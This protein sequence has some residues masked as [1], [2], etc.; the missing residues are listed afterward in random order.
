[1]NRMNVALIGC[2]RIGYL[3][4]D[5]PLRYKPCTHFGGAVSAG[6]AVTA[7]CD[8]DSARLNDFSLR[9][10]IPPSRRYS[11]YRKLIDENVPDA[12]IISTWTASHAQIGIAA[13]NS[14]AKVIV[15]EK[16]ICAGLKEAGRFIDACKK[17]GTEL[18]INH[19]RRY[20]P[21]YGRVKKM[22]GSGTIGDV[23]TV[24]ASVL[25]SSWKAG[26]GAEGGG[27]PLLH[28]GT[29][30]IDIIRFF[31]GDITSVEG[32]FQ[33]TGRKNG[34]EDRATAWLT[35]ESGVDVFLEAGGSRQYFV[36]E[37]VISGTGGKIVIGNG[38]EE[39]H[40]PRKSRFYTGF[41]D[42]N[43]SRFPA[44][45]GKNYFTALYCQVK[46]LLAGRKI[47]CVSTGADG[48]RA[49]E[50]IHAIYLSAHHGRKRIE[51]PVEPG[52]IN[53]SKIFGHN[54]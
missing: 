35:T 34:F 49:L 22:I 9:A 7:A 37:I 39:L 45:T 8:I 47:D 14:G 33:R 17:S 5:D 27:G 15:C 48:Y 32:E 6:L 54:H 23:K 41:R 2:G 31:F 16:P 12:V 40:L 53:L 29:H 11:S 4:E 13:A 38:Y 50:A 43:R 1:M 3:L 24:W 19:E 21:R 36:F 44:T 51:L 30:L 42:L 52:R 46:N 10:G 28:D 20:D 25:T 18:I 26:R